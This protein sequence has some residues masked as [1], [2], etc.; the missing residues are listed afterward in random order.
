[1]TAGGFARLSDEDAGRHALAVV[2]ERM[3]LPDG[4]AAAISQI[5]S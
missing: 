2:N 5:T 4:P 3:Q 1:V